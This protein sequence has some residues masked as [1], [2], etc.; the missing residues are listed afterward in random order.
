MSNLQSEKYVQW[1]RGQS[2]SVMG[3]FH[4]AWLEVVECWDSCR[5]HRHP[6]LKWVGPEHWLKVALVSHTLKNSQQLHF[7]MVVFK[8]GVWCV[9]DQKWCCKTGMKIKNTAKG[10]FD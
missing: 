3:I 9:N 8:S 1:S 4:I 2:L 5:P 10:E 6:K 7:S